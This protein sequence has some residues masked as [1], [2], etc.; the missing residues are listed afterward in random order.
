[1][2]I[3]DRIKENLE[4]SMDM[5]RC[6][7]QDYLVW[8]WIPENGNT[9]RANAIRI[10]S[11]LRVK[12]GEAAVFVYRQNNGI[13][14]EVIYGPYDGIIETKNFPLLAN[15][16]AKAYGGGTP[17]QADIYFINLAGV[18]QM[19]FGIP[20]T[21]TADPRFPD[22]FVPVCAGGTMSFRIA[23]IATFVQ[24]HR[25]IN[26]TIDDL[27]EQ[28]R[29]VVEKVGKAVISNAPYSYNV[30]LA[31]IERAIDSMSE[32][33]ERKIGP[34]MKDFGIEMTRWD[35]TRVEPDRNSTGWSSLINITRGRQEAVLN[36]QTEMEVRNLREMQAINS[37]NMAESLRVQREELQRAQRLQS[38]TSYIGA[39]AINRQADVLQ[40]AAENLGEM[41]S[42]GGG[43]EGGGGMMNPAGM[44]AG[45]YMGGA[46]GGQ[47]MQMMNQ[48]NA[49]AAVNPATPGG[50]V[51]P[52]APQPQI[53]FY[54]LVNG[55]QSG[56]FDVTQLQQLV[57][58]GSL[59][60]V[61][62]VWRAGMTQW[63]QASNV[64]E[65]ASLFTPGA[66]AVPPPPPVTP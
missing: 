50:M 42:L 63:E 5:I 21:M 53:S 33:M 11:S 45:M 15:L 40:A 47:F 28:V 32:E 22:F 29:R 44:M 55:T 62:Y 52:P 8:H 54:V 2:G 6:D 19:K 60:P 23:D 35:L 51:P 26:F 4:G 16:I 61:T 59:T 34:E 65:T 37:E 3:F 24:K 64:P 41:S 7:Q 13:S 48:M 12:A 38:E 39:H 49:S 1:M 31:Q 14:Q 30:P 17:F 20:Y 46:V 58:N 25:M 57:A 56:P 66:G 9:Q 10:G 27:R 36:T 18:V 43:G